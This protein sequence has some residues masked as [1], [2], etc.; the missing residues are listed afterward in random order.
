M[1]KILR[2]VTGE[3]IIAD[4]VHN[5]DGSVSTTRPALMHMQMLD[6]GGIG[7]GMIPYHPWTEG[8]IVFKAS[9]LLGPPNDVD[10]NTS[11]GYNERFNPDAIIVPG[12]GSGLLLG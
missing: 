4:V 3:V 6:K 8:P 11:R 7:V 2:L 1:I 5:D 12:G 10:E 9:A